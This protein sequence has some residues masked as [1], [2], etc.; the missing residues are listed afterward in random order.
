M[1]T[2]ATYDPETDELIVRPNCW[3]YFVFGAKMYIFCLLGKYSNSFGSKVLDH[4]WCMSCQ[5]RSRICPIIRR[6]QKRGHS[7]SS[8][9]LQRQKLECE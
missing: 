7:W 4:K 9:S 1:E 8:R 5:T 6:W 2:T 3:N